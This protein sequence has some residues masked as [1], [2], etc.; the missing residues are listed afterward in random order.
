MNE[1]R[2]VMYN[3][4][5]NK[6]GSFDWVWVVLNEH[7]NYFREY[8]IRQRILSQV[9]P[10]G[11]ITEAVSQQSDSFRYKHPLHAFSAC[12][13]SDVDD[14]QLRR[15]EIH[16]RKASVVKDKSLGALVS[17]RDLSRMFPVHFP[18]KK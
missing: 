7:Y 12:Y 14:T 4:T 9:P 17:H 13:E 15:H 5:P 2:I 1:G 6:R 8:G 16:R 10:I 18:I 11:G 3:V